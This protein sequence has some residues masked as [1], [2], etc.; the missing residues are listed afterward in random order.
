MGLDYHESRGARLYEAI[1]TWGPYPEVPA[2]LRTLATRY[3]LII[4]SNASDQQIAL[5]VARMGAPFERVLT[6]EQAQAYKPRLAAFLYLFDALGCRPEQLI[7]VS[8]SITYDHRPAADL[9]IGTRIWVN[10]EEL[11]DLLAALKGTVG[12]YSAPASSKYEVA[13]LGVATEPTL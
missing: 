12:Y 13:A 9:A 6:A 7:H 2:A 11:E 3:P 1:G 4:L 5:N 8:A 10:R